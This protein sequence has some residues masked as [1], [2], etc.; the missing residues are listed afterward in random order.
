M[1][2]HAILVGLLLVAPAAK[3]APATGYTP[4]QARLLAVR[5][6]QVDGYERLADLVLSA[7]LPDGKTVG[8]VLGPAGD[9]EIALRLL[10]RSA[11]VVGDPR[12]YSDGVAEVDVEIPADTVIE[13]MGGQ[14]FGILRGLAVDGYLRATGRGA[15]LPD[16]SPEMVKKAEATRLTE[17][18]EIFPTGWDRVTAAGRVEAES[19]ARIRA[20]AAMQELVRG[21]HISPSLT[22]AQVVTEAPAAARLDGFIRSLPVA[23][24]VRLM[25]DRVAEADV[26][27]PVR[28]LIRV[29][30]GIRALKPG[31]TRWTDAQ[32]DQLSVSLKTDRLVATGRGMPPLTDIRP[33]QDYV[34]SPA[35]PMPDWAATVLEARGQAR[36]PEDIESDV[37]NED[38][39]RLL[40]ARSAKVKAMADLG[41]QLDSVRLSDGRTVRER[42]AKDEA[43][44][45]DIA[46]FLASARV[47]QSKALADGQQWEVTM[48]LPLIRL[49]EFSRPRS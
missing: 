44:R 38:Q 34:G 18:V 22:V 46:T 3:P 29:L 19:R 20:Y 25:P 6:A 1:L 35:T 5:V 45:Q 27:A 37:K 39:A 30:R 41:R 2:I 32:V 7:P 31:D 12:V 10:L 42:A 40:A 43:F 11:R 9:R 14:E 23:G 48:R 21:I 47:T 16:I 49:W 17:F 36:P 24:P 15:P 4:E 8:A 28:D 13:G 26:A 33:A